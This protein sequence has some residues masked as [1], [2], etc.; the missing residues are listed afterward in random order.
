MISE[1]LNQMYTAVQQNTDR[2]GKFRTDL[3]L[4]IVIL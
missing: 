4:A 3:I 2:F 1:A